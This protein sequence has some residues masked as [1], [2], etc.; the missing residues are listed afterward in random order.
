MGI[1]GLADP[2]FSIGKRDEII[3]WDKEKKKINLSMVMD[4]FVIGSL[5]PY[6]MILGGK[7]VASLLF[8]NQVRKDFSN[9][10][11]GN[12]SLIS[13]RV[14]SGNLVLIT[15]L[16]ALGKSVMYDR[17]RLTNG[18]K[19]I[20]IGYSEG[21]GEFHFNGEIYEKM[22]KLVLQYKPPSQKKKE[23]GTGFRNKREVVR[24][25]LSL[26]NI[27]LNYNIHGIKRE[28][29]L[30]PLA[31][32]FHDVLCKNVKPDYYDISVNEISE[33][34]IKRWIIQRAKRRPE[35]K[36]WENKEYL[37]WENK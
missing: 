16:S 31:K 36:K 29:F 1:L 6:S 20:S 25:A 5:P 9:K 12:K 13:G 15:T 24:K 17:I 10:Y 7:L 18:Q 27:S 35:F 37:L 34:M 26:L 3:G 11:K 21:Y 8:S 22:K 33:Y 19:F 4:G 30:I 14:H 32:N 2:V 23:W 28:Q